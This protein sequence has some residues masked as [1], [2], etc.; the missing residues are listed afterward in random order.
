MIAG[1]SSSLPS[2]PPTPRLPPQP[3]A[4]FFYVLW[5]I[6]Q[7]KL[8]TSA[9]SSINPS[10]LP[11]HVIIRLQT[12]STLLPSFFLTASVVLQAYVVFPLGYYG[13]FLTAL[14]TFNLFYSIMRHD[15]TSHVNPSIPSSK[16]FQEA[17]TEWSPNSLTQDSGSFT[18]SLVT[19]FANLVL[20]FLPTATPQF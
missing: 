10:L 13:N 12:L 16:T 20:C 6:Q 5:T 2:P 4:L 9:F 18:I 7:P 3:P 1:I 17:P 14:F 19:Y 11:P 8:D 15:P